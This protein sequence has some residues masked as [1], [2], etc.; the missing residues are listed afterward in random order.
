MLSSK[1]YKTPPDAAQAS[2]GF[3][4]EVERGNEKSRRTKTI[5]KSC[6]KIFLASDPFMSQT[7]A[8]RNHTAM[9]TMNGDGCSFSVSLS[10]FLG[11]SSGTGG[12]PRSCSDVRVGVCA[13]VKS[14]QSP[15]KERQC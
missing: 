11:K 15:D 4:A 5:I 7:R 10:F 12:M 9:M 3:R 1:F 14:V 8:S 2:S 13:L 6:N